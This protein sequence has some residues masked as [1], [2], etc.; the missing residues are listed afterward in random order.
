M[1]AECKIQYPTDGEKVPKNGENM[2]SSFPAHGT[3]P[4]SVGSV[5]GVLVPSGGGSEIRGQTLYGPPEWV[6]SFKGVPQGKYTFSLRAADQVTVLA[7]SI[8]VQVGVAAEGRPRRFQVVMTAPATGDPPLTSP[9]F[10]W[11]YTDEDQLIEGRLLQEGGV[12]IP[13]TVVQQPQPPADQDWIIRFD[14]VPPGTGYVLSVFNTVGTSAK[15]DGL[16]VGS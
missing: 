1:M 16:T 14:N 6:I 11:G 9:V 12:A 8:N 3:C 4:L 2:L 7:E 13:G 5:V 15:C 10:A